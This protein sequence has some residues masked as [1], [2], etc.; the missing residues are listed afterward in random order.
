MRVGSTGRSGTITVPCEGCVGQVLV[1]VNRPSDHLFGAET[2]PHPLGAGC[3][4]PG[5]SVGFLK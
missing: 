4:A 1:G 2:L 3:P 5:S